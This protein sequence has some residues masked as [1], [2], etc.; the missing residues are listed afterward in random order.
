MGVTTRHENVLVELSAL[1]ATGT[2][3]DGHPLS[4]ATLR[5]LDHDIALLEALLAQ[6]R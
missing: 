6:A 4:E 2:R 5:A 3:P 1:R